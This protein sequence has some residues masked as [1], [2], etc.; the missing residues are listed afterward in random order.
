MIYPNN[1]EHKLGFDEIRRLLK[2][3]CLS[4]LGK[5]KVDEIAFSTDC[6]EINE[7]MNQVREFRRLKEEKDDF[8]MQFFF[9]VREAVTRIRMENTHL[10]EDEVWDLR[11]SLETIANIVRYLRKESG[12][13]SQESVDYPYP[14]LQRLTEGVVTFPAVIRRIDSILDK[15][16]KIKDSASMTL[17]GIRHELEK[18][19][20][21]ISR[22]LY[23]ILHAAQK[24]GLVDK[25]AAP[26]MRDGR[27]V[28]PVAPQVKR[29]INGIVH[30]E[31]AT[32]KT[33]F[34]EPTEVVEANNKVRQLEAEERREI[35]RILTV[36]TDEV[37]PHV[38]EIL[39][40]YQFLAQIDL[41]QAKAHWAELTKA[42]EPA[43]ED[44]PHIDWIH[45]VH[46][47]LQLSLEKQGKKVVPLEIR[48]EGVRS[49]E[50]GDRRNVGR[51][52]IISGPNAGGKSVCLKTVGLLQ[53]MLQC[54]LPIPIGD[55]STA[56]I[57][58]HI[59][60][61]IGDEQSIEN[62]LSTYSSHLMN[63]KQMMK[64][65]NART[66]LLIDE[67]GSG[68]EP[69]IGGAI[70]E[71]MLKQFWQ[72]ETFG[73]ITTHYQN[74]KQFA[75]GHP[76]VVNGA[77]LYD[78]H[79][80]QALFQLAI[81]QPGSSFA[82]EIAR[83]TGIPEEVIKDASDIVGS[84]YIQSDKY[85]QDI[86]RDKRYWEGKRQTIHQHEKSLESKINRYEDELNEIERQRKEILRK[87]KEQAEELLRESNKKI[88]NAI[89]EIREAQAEKER[90]RLAREEL[91]TFKE[92]L[93]TIDTRDNDE[94]IARKIRQIQE[95]K[96]RK[97]KRKAEKLARKEEGGTRNENT[98]AA[99]NSQLSTANSQLK[100][101]DTVRIKGLTSVGEIESINGSQ[102]VVIFGGMRTKMR[103]DRLERAE[104]PTTQLSKTEERNNNIAGSYGMVSKDTREVIDNR[105]LNFR[106]DLDVRGMRGDE[107]INAVTYFIDDAILVGMPR[108]RILHGTGTGVLRQLIRQYLATIPNVTHYRDEHVQF[109]GAG[110]TVVDLD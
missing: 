85:L 109:G 95:R 77:M 82:I 49:Q 89:R 36:F 5:E 27:L 74:L 46:P 21:S 19:Q 44:K 50:S 70:A 18:T 14:A 90:T 58:E 1:F 17:A 31:S 12:D 65:A 13:G 37:R 3:R 35:I 78:R 25:D 61:D 88:E 7:W 71:A 22:T 64:Q 92:Q 47:L 42:F 62:D 20:G 4:T 29:R 86:V 43:L 99:A 34:I 97:E 100:P 96:E 48:L 2:E 55:R 87:A 39:D 75:E 102:A 28:I 108:V 66:L 93:D 105:K 32:G 56:G 73:V 72:R 40:S 52:L 53:Y 54:G 80:M 41:I 81:G 10:E 23:T 11:R 104:K 16:G 107:A 79:E 110:I 59:M 33:V 24:D 94:A 45:A 15:F 98:S 76:G 101:G 26:A 83:K 51:L 30:D 6:R 69:T 60:I 84:E 67:F 103:A 38:K 57:F 106:Q 8:P 63:M 68:T 9:D 91:N